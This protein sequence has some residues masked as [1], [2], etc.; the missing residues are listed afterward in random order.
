MLFISI[1]ACYKTDTDHNHRC[2]SERESAATVG[3]LSLQNIANEE[4]AG[5][6]KE[7]LELDPYM[8]AKGVINAAV[9]ELEPAEQAN[10]ADLKSMKEQLNYIAKCFKFL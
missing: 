3:V 1:D 5:R 2:D 6:I 8:K 10:L 9:V 4:I 7:Y